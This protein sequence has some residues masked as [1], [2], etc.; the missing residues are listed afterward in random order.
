MQL[1]TQAW[2]TRY[3]IAFRIGLVSSKSRCFHCSYTTPD[4]HAPTFDCSYT[5]LS[6]SALRCLN[7]LSLTA[8]KPNWSGTTS[9][10][11]S[12][13]RW[14]A[15]RSESDWFSPHLQSGVVSLREN[16]VEWHRIASALCTWTPLSDAKSNPV[17]DESGI[18]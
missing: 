14:N 3:R 5:I 10:W 17:C 12:Y 13:T 9:D 8:A 11:C 6:R 2:V 1:A 7:L 16:G 18:V 4:W 15:E